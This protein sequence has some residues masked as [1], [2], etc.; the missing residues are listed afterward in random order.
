MD[1]LQSYKSFVNSHYLSE[2]IR[3]T[4]GILLPAIVLSQFGLLPIGLVLSVGALCVS[5]TDNAGPIHHRRTG[6]MV[7]N[8]AIFLV[9]LV[10]GFTTHSPLLLGII[11]IIFCF[12][13][14]ML[15]VFGTRASSI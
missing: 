4:V 13:F 5:G 10:V 2:G 11:L 6:M 3:M 12:F 15:G 8:A 9:A 14:S 7:C 1:Y